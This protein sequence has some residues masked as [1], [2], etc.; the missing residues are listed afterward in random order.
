MV[1]ITALTACSE[2]ASNAGVQSAAEAGI[3]AAEGQIDAPSEVPQELSLTATADEVTFAT[4]EVTVEPGDERYVC[5]AATLPADSEVVV[6]EISGEYGAGTHHVF[7]GWTLTPEPEGFTEC[8]VLFKLTWIPVYLGGVNTSPLTMPEGAGVNLETGKQ[9]LLQLHLQN[10]TEDTISNRVTMRMKRVPSGEPYTP[11]GIFGLHNEA[12]S[13]PPYAENAWTQMSCPAPKAMN[14]FGVLG[15]MH[16]LGQL[17]QF[18]KNDT[19]V[20]E[21]P[22]SFDDQPIT[23]F[24]TTIATGDNLQLAC[25]HSNPSDRT[26]TYGGKLRHGDVRDRVLLH[27]VR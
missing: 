12:I 7:F 6:D 21:Q 24:E 17:L 14:V 16:K 19:M 25:A 15:H 13:I 8:P 2:E 22:W 9:L 3:D 27:A 5:W 23:P 1:F 18:S 20:F 11:A 26:V 4:G 10:T